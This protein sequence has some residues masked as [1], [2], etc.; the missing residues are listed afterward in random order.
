MSI[1]FHINIADFN[2]LFIIITMVLSFSIFRYSNFLCPHVLEMSL[3]NSLYLSFISFSLLIG[4]LR[5]LYF[6]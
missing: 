4:M 2:F 1:L 6:M 5:D 3:M